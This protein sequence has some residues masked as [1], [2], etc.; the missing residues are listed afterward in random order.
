MSDPMRHDLM[1]DTVIPA[2][3]SQGLR[4]AVENGAI[5]L[6]F[7]GDHLPYD[8][9]IRHFLDTELSVLLLRFRPHLY[10]RDAHKEPLLELGMALNYRRFGPKWGFDA[11]DG[12][13]VADLELPLLR[14]SLSQAD[15]ACFFALANAGFIDALALLARVRWGGCTARRALGLEVGPPGSR[16]TAKR[17]A[18]TPIEREVA[19]L[20]DR[21]EEPGPGAA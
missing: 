2:L 14:G 6:R 12:E 20:L 21:L 8:V 7:V 18:K 10:A 17:R 4:Y 1:S 11:P 13:V 9:T 3:D 19:D 16:P 5:H 15:F